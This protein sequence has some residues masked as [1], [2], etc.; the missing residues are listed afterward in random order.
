[1]R[2]AIICLVLFGLLALCSAGPELELAQKLAK[3]SLIS[4]RTISSQCQNAIRSCTNTLNNALASISA[5]DPQVEQKVCRALRNFYDC[6][7]RG[8]S[9]CYDAQLQQAL[10]DMLAQGRAA[11][12][13][14]FQGAS[15][16]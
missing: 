10:N 3:K 13:R 1:M 12:P 9:S 11:C 15:L 6:V 4:T 7:K 8:T 14:E 5:N 16:L 2:S